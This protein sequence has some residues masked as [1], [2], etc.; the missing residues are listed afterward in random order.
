MKKIQNKYLVIIVNILIFSIALNIVSLEPVCAGSYNGQDLALAI[1]KNQ[2]TLIDS[3]Y[4]DCD[5]ISHRQAIVLSSL[6]IMEPTDGL[7]FALFST[8]IAGS[9]PVTTDELN[10]GDE[11]GTYFR[12]KYVNPRD[13]SELIMTLQV[14]L[15]MHYLYYDVQFFSSEYPEYIGTKYN[16]RLTISV[17]SPSKGLSEYIF[18]VNNGYFVLDS[19]DISGTGFDIFAQSGNP[20]DVDLV[21]TTPRTPGA[22]AGA[23]DIIPIGGAVHPV[24]PG[25][26]ITVTIFIEDV[27][28]N[29][30]DSAAFID[31]LRFSGFAMTNIV[32]RKTVSDLNGGEVESNDVLKYRIT[33]SNIGTADQ[34]DN[35]GNEFDDYLPENTTYVPG[36]AYSEFGN[37]SYDSLENKIIW[38]GNVPAETSRVLDFKVTV[39]ESLPNGYIISN[40]GTV[41]WDS[42]ED[43]T[44]DATELTDDIY[45]DDDIDLDGDGETNDDDPTIVIVY[46]FDKPSF[47]T[48]DFSD[49]IPFEQATQLYLSREWFETFNSGTWGSRFE[50]VPIYHYSTS[51][52][53]KIQLRQSDGAQYWDYNL[54]SLGAD[55]IWWEI[56]FACGD[57]SEDYQLYL[58]LKNEYDQDIAKIR[59]DYI[60][61]SAKP[62]NWTLELFYWNPTN[63]W[64]QLESDF[65]GGYLGNSWYKLRIEKNGESYINYSISRPIRENVDFAI[66]GQ[67]A[68]PF[69]DFA[70]VEWISNTNPDPAVCPMFF[71][72]E[73]K[74]GL[75][76][77][78]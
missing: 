34:N 20:S 58:N 37:I 43:G 4:E 29:M 54:S 49:D 47:V 63:G 32:A 39:N 56:W 78:S 8:G 69:S 1:L 44:N 74:V 17:N 45:Y 67:L 16:D 36:S 12:S 10:P 61:K 55:M 19:N 42:D 77:Q 76:Y 23:S 51:Q 11:R 38:N 24:S 48:E 21:D 18:D 5:E 26:Q 64:N 30:F 2:S 46:S 50:V 35:P 41:Y 28:D 25:E 75:T 62:M 70:S 72:D 31:N 73:H 9:N 40:Q 15:Y 13:Y 53:F 27:G 33:I 52:S 66:A 3:T 65:K 60:N 7:T 22:D 59:F 68:A 14:P 57:T 71:I 6:G